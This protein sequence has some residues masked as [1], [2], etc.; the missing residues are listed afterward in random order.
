MSYAPPGVALYTSQVNNRCPPL[1][2][3]WDLACATTQEVVDTDI[4]PLWSRSTTTTTNF[5]DEA[6]KIKEVDSGKPEKFASDTGEDSSSWCFC[7]REY[8]KRPS[9]HIDSGADDHILSSRFC[10]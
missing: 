10:K 4:V 2:L 5:A 3:S 1:S 6:S 8:T 7:D 9:G